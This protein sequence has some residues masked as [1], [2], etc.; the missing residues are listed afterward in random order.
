MDSVDPRQ[1]LDKSMELRKAV[2]MRRDF[3]DL[4]PAGTKFFHPL[5]LGSNS[6]R[7]QRSISHATFQ[8]SWCMGNEVKG[9]VQR[10][11]MFRELFNSCGCF[12]CCCDFPDS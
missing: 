1:V 2:T 5:C 7:W 8:T 9:E 3:V 12:G 10:L 6:V 4:L 11:E